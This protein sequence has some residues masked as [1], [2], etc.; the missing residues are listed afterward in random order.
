MQGRPLDLPDHT[1]H[2]REGSARK[3]AEDSIAAVPTRHSPI[4]VRLLSKI[5]ES[6]STLFLEGK[7]EVQRRQPIAYAAA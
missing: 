1:P 5:A 4:G 6:P 2:R 3:L 7:I